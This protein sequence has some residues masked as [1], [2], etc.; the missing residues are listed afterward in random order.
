MVN[1]R[2]HGRFGQP[3]GKISRTIGKKLLASGKHVQ[4]FEGFAAFRPGAPMHSIVR[5]AQDEIRERS[6]GDTNPDVVIVLDNSLFGVVDI[7][8]GLK[9]GGTVMAAGL[10]ADILGSKAVDI[11]FI[12]I[13]NLLHEETEVEEDLFNALQ[14]HH[15]I[16]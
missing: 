11:T 15:I 8:K 16:N 5:F 3:V 14:I 7:T 9:T 1:I 2:F 6:T 13:A 12:N 4:V 10:E